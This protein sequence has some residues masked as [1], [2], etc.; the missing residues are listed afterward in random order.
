VP[1]EALRAWRAAGARGAP[2]REGW[3][4]LRDAFAGRHPDA[5]RE[6]ARRLG[7][8]LPAGWRADL[9]VFPASET[10]MATRVA[11]GQVLGALAKRVPEL[12]GGA[13]DLAPSTKTLIAGAADLERATPNGRN[14]HFG[15]R[16]HA[17]GAVLNGMAL[18]GGIRPFGATFLI[19]SDY[20]RPP[21]RLAAM[22]RQ[23]VIYVFTHDS[24]G[25]GEDGPTHQPI[26]QLAAMR[27]I[28]GFTVFRPA[29]ANETVEAWAQAMVAEGP[30]ALVLTR[31]N[32]PV[33]DRARYAPAAGLARGAYV[34]SDAEGSAP[35]VVL[36]G[37]G[38]EVPMLL[39]AQDLL[40]AHG[41]AARTVSVPSIERFLAQPAA[42]RDE[43]LPPSL[44]HR[45][46]MEAAHPMP[47]YRLVGSAG[48]VIGLE[49]FGASAPYQRLYQELGLTAEHV[50]AVARGMLGR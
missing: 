31:Q 32:L 25:L 18:H 12:V 36:L 41:I 37:S 7:G 20:M 1:P 46:A 2:L 38:S 48:A 8:E 35:D 4:R 42:Y 43:V 21:M 17:M 40:L 33:L 16:E 29:D 34:L 3:E 30:V 44:H 23:R 10:G 6:L 9:P 5:A 14:M 22:M 28:P 45:I 11:S 49:R 19:F 26:E 50:V 13:A 39:A 27:A 24:I 15:I 47:W